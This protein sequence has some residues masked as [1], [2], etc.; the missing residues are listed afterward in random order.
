[1][2]MPNWWRR[3]RKS[4]LATESPGAAVDARLPDLRE[5]VYLDEVSLRSLLSSQKGG[6]TD[7]TSEHATDVSEASLVGTLGANS[8]LIAKAEFESRYQTSNSSTIQTSRKATV[9]SWFREFHE[10]DGLRLMQPVGVSKAAGDIA[11][12]IG[13]DDPSLLVEGAELHR[14]ALVEC[15]VKLSADPVFHLGT[16]VSEFTAMAHDYPDMF[17]ANGSLDILRGAKPMNKILQRLLAGLIPIRAMSIDYVVVE[18]EG[19]E[20]VAHRDLVNGLPLTSKPLELVGVTE[21][22]AYWKDIRRVLFSDAEFT[23]LCRISKTGLQDSWTPVKLA[24]LFSGV[25]PDLVEQLNAAGRVPFAPASVGRAGDVNET[26]LREALRVYVSMLVDAVEAPLNDG[27]AA[28]VEALVEKMPVDAMTVSGQRA[29]FDVITDELEGKL[30][31]RPE[32]ACALAMRDQARRSVGLSLF[33]DL[34][35]RVVTSRESP[36]ILE[37]PKVLRLLDVDVVAIYW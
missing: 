5:F 16:M 10:I 34:Q 23:M 1:M 37:P 20:H 35:S 17:A 7:T 32:A 14:G 11:E 25:A 31:G 28:F 19:V 29:A 12:L 13:V 3:L 24:D 4:P 2:R 6:V 22:L 9:Q 26:R 30:G 27:E 8:P 18:L 33:P 21:H 15:R 36:G